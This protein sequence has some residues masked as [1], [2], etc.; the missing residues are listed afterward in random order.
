MENKDDIRLLN[1]KQLEDFLINKNHEKY[2]V[3]QILDWV[4]NKGAMSP[5]L[6]MN[7]TAVDLQYT[8]TSFCRINPRY[9][10]ENKKR[11]KNSFCRPKRYRNA[12]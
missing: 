11:S 4:W 7:R 9:W 8:L 1:S 3:N 12:I 10:M 6:A 5:D 2:R